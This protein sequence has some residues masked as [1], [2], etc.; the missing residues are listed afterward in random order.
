MPASLSD[1][2]RVF[3]DRSSFCC[4]YRFLPDPDREFSRDP[5]LAASWGEFRLFSKGRNLCAAS[6][7]G[8]FIDS[9]SWYLLP[10][11]EWMG[12]SRVHILHER[13]FPE[14]V[15]DMSRHTPRG[16][17]YETTSRFLDSF[18]DAALE[19]LDTW[20]TWRSRHALRCAQAG[21]IFPDIFFQ[22]V[23][24]AVWL[25]WGHAPQP[26]MAESYRF[27][28]P[29]GADAVDFSFFRL[30]VDGLLDDAL[31]G[32]RLRCP[33]DAR[34]AELARLLERSRIRED[35]PRTIMG[36]SLWENVRRRFERTSGPLFD[37]MRE[38]EF[39]P[40]VAM[41]GSLAPNISE[42][43][44]D[45]VARVFFESASSAALPDIMECEDVPLLPECA[46]ATQ[47][48]E[49][50]EQSLR[51]RSWY[52]SPCILDVERMTEEAGVSVSS[53]AL[54]DT[55]VKA[56]ALAGGGFRPAVFLNERNPMVSSEPGRRFV[57][58]HELCHLL[59]DRSYGRS[60]AM[61]TGPWAP[62][63]VEKRANAFAAMLL[64]PPALL[65]KH[66]TPKNPEEV[67]S[68]AATLRVGK[69]TL[70]NH[71]FN[72]GYIDAFRR[73]RLLESL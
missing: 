61:A 16:V 59:H 55:D 54:S 14:P 19:R 47:G 48:Y 17:F 28:E 10:L 7:Q 12:G 35:I 67:R 57:L 25:S 8:E 13:A 45:S 60:L 63:G 9:V 51:K 56:L 20:L 22:R 65:E 32:L 2:W 66:P 43:D 40:L 52:E 30:T 6:V 5:A 44:V 71:L 1:G 24:N 53:V 39:E 37:A 21:G 50:A 73:E 15:E 33:E 46:P 26:G 18:T 11:F 4:E 36:D 31:G 38:K 69:R 23:Q 58:A 62:C 3:G 41:F 49:L 64:L 29:S 34:I 27:I 68:L 70:V 42:E 72:M